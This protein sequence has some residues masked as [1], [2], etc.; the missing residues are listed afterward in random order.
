MGKKDKMKVKPSVRKLHSIQK[1]SKIT[2]LECLAC[3]ILYDFPSGQ[4]CIL[5]IALKCQKNDK[6]INCKTV[7]ILFNNEK[8]T[9]KSV[10]L[11]ARSHLSPNSSYVRFIYTF[12]ELYDT[13]LV[14]Y[15]FGL[16]SHP[17][18]PLPISLL[19]SISLRRGLHT[20]LYITSCISVT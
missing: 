20:S 2:V 7:K 16:C 18:I 10:R 1:S 5:I 17:V 15:F 14:S 19:D 12:Q 9:Q 4:D 8:C 3:V 11:S 6:F 13:F